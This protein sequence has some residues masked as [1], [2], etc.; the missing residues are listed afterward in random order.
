MSAHA[1]QA[2][3]G[4]AKGGQILW[5]VAKLDL[6]L[7]LAERHVAHPVQALD[8]PM[9]LPTAH[10]QSRVGTLAREAADGMLHLGRRLA[11]AVR[12]AL[13]AADLTEA[14]PVQMLGQTRAGLKMSLDSPPMPFARR[15]SFRERLLPLPL[16]SGGKIPAES[17]P[18][19]RPSTRAGCL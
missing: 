16:G 7:V 1:E 3:H 11:L 5:S 18:Q 17:L 4:I 9:G 10:Q 2:D 15:A 13:Q 19:W 6:A 12:G 14:R 8:A